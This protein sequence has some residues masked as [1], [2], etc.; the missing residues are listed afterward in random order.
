[1]KKQSIC[2]TPTDESNNILRMKTT[3]EKIKPRNRLWVSTHSHY[4]YKSTY[5]NYNNY[6]K[7]Q[8]SRE[9]CKISPSELELAKLCLKIDLMSHPAHMEELVNAHTLIGISHLLKALST[10]A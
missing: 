4:D 1:M 2:V 9:D 6:Q 5:Y 10:C 8:H 3:F 7:P